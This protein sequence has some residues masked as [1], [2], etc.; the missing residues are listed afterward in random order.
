[1]FGQMNGG[2]FPAR[3]GGE[4][5]AQMQPQFGV[6]RRDPDRLFGDVDRLGTFV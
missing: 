3:L 1:M 5:G 6:G 4:Q 2:F